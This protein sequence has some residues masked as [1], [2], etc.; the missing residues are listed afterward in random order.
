[1][2]QLVG[3]TIRPRGTPMTSDAPNAAL[4]AAFFDGRFMVEIRERNWNFHLALSRP[5][6]PLEYRFQG[7]L[8]YSRGIEVIGRVRAPNP[9]RGKLM[10][11][12]L[13]P[14]GPETTFGSDG[15]DGVG[16]FYRERPDDIGSDFQANLHLPEGA[17]SL[18]LSLALAPCGGTSTSGSTSFKATKRPLPPFRSRPTSIRISRS[19]LDLTSTLVLA[20]PGLL[21]ARRPSSG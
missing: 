8:N 2:G 16:Q 6:V 19:G 12:W 7:G 20:D 3:P 15:L 18:P 10:R 21:P 13:S 4:D 11:I 14:F 1:M 5:E 17:L 9:H